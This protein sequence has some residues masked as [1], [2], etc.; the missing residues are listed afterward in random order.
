VHQAIDSALDEL[1]TSVVDAI[2][3][4]HKALGP[5]L[6]ESAY[7]TCLCI[8]LRKRGIPF[9]AQE[10][11]AI[12]Y[13]GETVDA[14]LRLDLS[15]DDRLIVEIKSVERLV[16][17]HE[18]QLLTYLKLASKRLGLLVNFNV[19]LIKQGIKRIVL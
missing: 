15:V 12:R 18:A 19:A 9:V 14:A 1:A 16:P 11:V 2:F 6:L 5:G 8:E 4:V 10:P 17:V 3:N 13:R 7:Q